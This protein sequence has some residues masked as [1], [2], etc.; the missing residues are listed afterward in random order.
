MS[1]VTS[2]SLGLPATNS[3]RGPE[4]SCIEVLDDRAHLHVAKLADIEIAPFVTAPPA[5]EEI[6][7]RLHEPL[8]HHNSLA[9]VRHSST[10]RLLPECTNP[11]MTESYFLLDGSGPVPRQVIRWRER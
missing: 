6:A 9:M 3:P 10:F 4:I 8:A 2:Q 11:H 5:Q 1:D 7:R